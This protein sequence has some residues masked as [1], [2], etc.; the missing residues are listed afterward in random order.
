MFSNFPATIFQMMLKYF[1][2]TKSSRAPWNRP[3]E[4]KCA[5]KH[6]FS[7]FFLQCLF[8]RLHLMNSGSAGHLWNGNDRQ[9]NNL[10][11]FLTQTRDSS[12]SGLVEQL[13]TLHPFS[14]CP[15]REVQG[16]I[17]SLPFLKWRECWWSSSSFRLDKTFGLPPPCPPPIAGQGKASH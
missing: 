15:G 16:F 4:T 13:S 17:H 5:A 1:F 3:H 2:S 14:N 9:M 10:V 11:Q 8:T 12:E 6:S 7:L